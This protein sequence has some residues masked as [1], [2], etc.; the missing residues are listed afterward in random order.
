VEFLEHSEVVVLGHN[1]LPFKV[2]S[3]TF[4]DLFK[5]MLFSYHVAIC[6]TIE[7]VIIKVI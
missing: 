7:S 1:L 3:D 6:D 5:V 2:F 4:E